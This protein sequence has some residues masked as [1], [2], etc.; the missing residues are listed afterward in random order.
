M[1]RQHSPPAM[2]DALF[3]DVAGQFRALSEPARLRILQRLMQG[4]ATVG[5]LADHLGTSQANA[6]KHVAVLAAVGFVTR[7]RD[8][9][10]IVCAIGDDV[11]RRLCDLMCT[12]ALDQAQRKLAGVRAPPPVKPASRPRRPKAASAAP[13]RES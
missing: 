5:E 2:S 10:S 4:D 9:T 12:R 13:R 7:R 1:S 11:V 8:G 6:S 3:D